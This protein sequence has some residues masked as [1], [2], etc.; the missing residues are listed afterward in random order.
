MFDATAILFKVNTSWSFAAQQSI[1]LFGRL[2]RFSRLDF[3]L[4]RDDHGGGGFFVCLS[5]IEATTYRV[6][7]E[8]LDKGT[9]AAAEDNSTQHW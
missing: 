9:G 8:N 2:S 1:L 5:I 3:E 6:G 7:M 4:V